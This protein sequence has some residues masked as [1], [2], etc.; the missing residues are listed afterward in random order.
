M[1]QPR[2]PRPTTTAR[3]SLDAM[4]FGGRD[5][6]GFGAGVDTPPQRFWEELAAARER[7]SSCFREHCTDCCPLLHDRRQACVLGPMPRSMCEPSLNR[8]EDLQTSS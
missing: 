7:V 2:P 4:H 5:A 6:D 1:Q 8:S 3:A